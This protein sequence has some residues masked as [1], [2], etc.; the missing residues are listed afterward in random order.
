MN[1]MRPILIAGPTAS[2][3][4]GLALRLAEELG[5]IVIN[6]DSM[7]VYRE[8]RILTARPS[9]AEEQRAPHALYGFVPGRESYSA[10]RYAR[11]VARVLGEAQRAGQRPIIVGGTGLY[12]KTLTEGLSPIPAVPDDVRQHWRARGAEVGAG[13]LHG[14]LS[15][16]DPETAG[17]LAPTDTQRIVRALEVLEATGVSLA[18]WQRV[19]RQKIIDLADAVPLLVQVERD[20]LYRRIDERFC[21]MIDAGALD[22]VMQLERLGLDPAL[23]LLSSL[24]VGPLRRHLAGEVSLE[25]ALGEG[26][27]ES[28]QYAKRQL[29]WARSNMIAWYHVSAQEMK[30]EVAKI[31]SLVQ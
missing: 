7:Q 23:P 5:G 28:R 3:K 4:S 14:E 25:A 21:A 17:R 24:G 20:E 31:V 13:V 9:A 11:D 19:P 12:F 16:R 10:G 26:Q 15:A 1:D 27:T 29:T 2:G 18:E 8:L 30:S 22:E 6:A